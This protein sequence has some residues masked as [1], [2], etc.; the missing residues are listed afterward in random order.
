MTR[1]NK[2]EPALHQGHSLDQGLQH[3][4]SPLDQPYQKASPTDN[5][6]MEAKG[7]HGFGL[8]AESG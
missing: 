5:R 7:L 2:M 6:P 4:G 8:S 3:W 1:E